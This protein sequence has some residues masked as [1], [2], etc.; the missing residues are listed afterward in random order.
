[1]KPAGHIPKVL[2]LLLA[3]A[4]A[5]TVLV[6]AAPQTPMTLPVLG[7]NAVNTAPAIKISLAGKRAP[8]PEPAPTPAPKPRPKPAPK[9]EPEPEPAPEPEP[10]PEPDPVP[11]P[12]TVPE[13]KPEPEPEPQPQP[14][15][16][17]VT[18]TTAEQAPA[19]EPIGE[20]AEADDSQNAVQL[21]NAGNSSDVDS[22]LSKLS[23]HLARHYDYP[24]RARRLGQQGTPVV[25]FEFSRDGTLLNHSLRDSSGH[26]LLDDAAQDMLIQAAPLPRVP[27]SMRGKSFTYALPVR[28]SLR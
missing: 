28:F 24:R 19:E 15:K 11:E 27:E 13:P 9:P 26:R 1:M 5:A 22:Y 12:E 23:R 6:W 2:F 25:V 18:E 10:I 17:E 21:Q 7:D 20:E 4:L 3:V 14:E 8:E 16:S